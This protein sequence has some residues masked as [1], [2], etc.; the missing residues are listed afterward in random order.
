MLEYDDEA[1]VTCLCCGKELT[2][3]ERDAGRD[4]CFDCYNQAQ[5]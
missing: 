5:D 3:E 4:E 1:S 2:E